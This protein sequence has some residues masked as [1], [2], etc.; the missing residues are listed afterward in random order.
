M[1]GLLPDQ[2]VSLLFADE[3]GTTRTVLSLVRGGASTLVFADRSG[4]AKVGMGVDARGQSTLTLPEPPES[5]AEPAEAPDAPDSAPLAAPKGPSPPAVALG[6]V[7]ARPH[8]RCPR[9]IPATGSFEVVAS[10]PPEKVPLTG[11]CFIPRAAFPRHGRCPP[12]HR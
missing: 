2:T 5:R 6:S 7:L 11:L 12:G 10:K 9:C 4:S 8:R 3:N 1:L